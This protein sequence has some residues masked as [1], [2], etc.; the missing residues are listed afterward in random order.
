G[1]PRVD[2]AVVEVRER[3]AGALEAAAAEADAAALKL[4]RGEDPVEAVERALV[5]RGVVFER[6]R[7]AGDERGLGGA[8]RAVQEDE[9]VDA[10]LAH[11]VG[12]RAVDAGLH[13]LLPDEVVAAAIEGAVEELP[14][15]VAAARA[16]QL[17]GAEVVEDVLDV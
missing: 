12:E 5:E 15:T 2:E 13:V 1:E 6:A 17:L 8:V 14:A 11:E 7:D 3:G 10:P 16:A 9:L 4:L